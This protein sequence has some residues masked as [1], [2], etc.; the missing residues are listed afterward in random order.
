[1]ITNGKTSKINNPKGSLIVA[2]RNANVK[3]PIRANNPSKTVM[4]SKLVLIPWF[5]VN[6]YFCMLMFV[7]TLNPFLL[8]L[9]PIV[10]VI[11]ISITYLL[12]ITI[13]FT[14]L[15]FVINRLKTKELVMS[16][17]LVFLNILL[18]IFCLD[19]L[20]SI[21]LHIKTRNIE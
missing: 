7:G 14:E 4:I 20:G 18:F 13:S 6:F 9:A 21:L 2:Y 12:M 15:C 8:I 3:K 17:Y 10:A 11:E 5:I 19:C 1:M 16:K